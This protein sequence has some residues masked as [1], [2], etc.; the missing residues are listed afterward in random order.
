MSLEGGGQVSAVRS[1]YGHPIGANRSLP[2]EGSSSQEVAYHQ[3]PSPTRL[4]THSWSPLSANAARHRPIAWCSGSCV[5]TWT[6]TASHDTLT[7]RVSICHRWT[8]VVLRYSR[9]SEAK[10][11]KVTASRRNLPRLACAT[12]SS[13]RRG[14]SD[15]RK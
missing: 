5:K 8:T 7:G 14:T 4:M 10:K 15:L 9:K 12:I 1:P 2:P 3:R 11:P 6:K 13:S